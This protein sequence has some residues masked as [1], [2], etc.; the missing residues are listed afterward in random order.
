MLH[1]SHCIFFPDKS[2]RAAC[3]SSGPNVCSTKC[4]ATGNE[5]EFYL[6]RTKWK[7]NQR[8]GH[9]TLKRISADGVIIKRTSMCRTGVCLQPQ[10]AQ[11]YH[12]VSSSIVSRQRWTISMYDSV[13]QAWHRETQ[14]RNPEAE[15][16]EVQNWAKGRREMEIQKINCQHLQH[17]FTEEPT[18][19]FLTNCWC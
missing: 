12:G 16:H 10:N 3:S 1:W 14:M 13:S 4:T 5:A 9:L 2:K 11:I 18:Y 15:R 8:R 17:H 19:S 6:L 7:A